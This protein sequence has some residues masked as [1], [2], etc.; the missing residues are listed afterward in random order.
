MRETY[1]PDAE[2]RELWD[3][4]FAKWESALVMKASDGPRLSLQKLV[5][6]AKRLYRLFINY[7]EYAV[8]CKSSNNKA[9][10]DMWKNRDV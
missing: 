6:D 7:E 9:P 5:L 8:S 4:V 2:E 3:P 1:C 10:R